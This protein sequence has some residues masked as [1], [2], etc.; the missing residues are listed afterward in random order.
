MRYITGILVAQFC[1]GLLAMPSDAAIVR[2]YAG[3][4]KL[5]AGEVP[6]V[7]ILIKDI[8]RMEATVSLSFGSGLPN[9]TTSDY[10][11]V[12]TNGKVYPSWEGQ[13]HVVSVDAADHDPAANGTFKGSL[14]FNPEGVQRSWI[15]D[16]GASIPGGAAERLAKTQAIVKA[17][18][19]EPIEMVFNSPIRY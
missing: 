14:Q 12:R 8:G 2:G 10:S 19:A 15:S 5:M 13:A 9:L 7:T 16:I 4:S 11:P 3:T 1:L 17:L 6:A 18:M